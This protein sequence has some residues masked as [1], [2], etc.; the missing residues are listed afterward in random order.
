MH[1]W[2]TYIQHNTVPTTRSGASLP[3]RIHRI[4]CYQDTVLAK[5]ARTVRLV[6]VSTHDD[7]GDVMTPKVPDIQEVALLHLVALQGLDPLPV[8]QRLI[9]TDSTRPRRLCKH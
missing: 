7:Y 1:T 3:H 2:N 9:A 6:G 4:G 8:H 5:C